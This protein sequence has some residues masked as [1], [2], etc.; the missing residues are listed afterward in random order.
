M[1]SYYKKLGDFDVHGESEVIQ[2]LRFMMKSMAISQLVSDII[3]V[4]GL[5][6]NLVSSLAGANIKAKNLSV[7]IF[8]V[9]GGGGGQ[10]L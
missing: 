3:Y 10:L 7:A 9:Y 6:L 8:C 5:A 1:P 4:A 2:N